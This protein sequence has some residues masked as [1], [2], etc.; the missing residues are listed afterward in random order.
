MKNIRGILPI[1]PLTLLCGCGFHLAGTNDITNDFD[2]IILAGNNNDIL[3]KNLNKELS[4]EGV[5]VIIGPPD[6]SE[7]L[8]GDI[9]VLT[10]SELKNDS[11]VLSV[12]SDS[13]EIEYAYKNQ[14]SCTFFSRGYEPYLISSTLD[15]SFLNKS[16]ATLSQ[17]TEEQAIRNEVVD[18]FTGQILFRVR[19]ASLKPVKKAD[20]QNTDGKEEPTT[21]VINGTGG[22]SSEEKTEV[23][24]IQSD[25][26]LKKLEQEK[27]ISINP[28][29]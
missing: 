14:I 28:D 12:S 9:P 25:D 8:E 23:F 11:K 22:T 1:I 24:E 6:I 26:D 21:I 19:H 16:G 29:R 3:F 13:Q 4:L 20:E 10:C 2:E 5:N 17:L 15:R 7:Y 18:I 27:N